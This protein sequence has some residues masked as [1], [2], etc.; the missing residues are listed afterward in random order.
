MKT[1]LFNPYT[2]TPRH[3]S[4]I[5]S[6]PEGIMMLDPDEPIRASEPTPEPVAA[7]HRFR[8]PQKGTPGWSAWQPCAVGNR[9]SWEIDSQGY[10]VEYRALCVLAARA[11][12]PPAPT[13]GTE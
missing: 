12:L 7:Q 1:M 5:R 10:E 6:D 9:P 2:G 4:D 3:P 8:H 13:K 11:S